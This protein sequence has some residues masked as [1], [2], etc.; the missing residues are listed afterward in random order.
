MCGI[1]GALSLNKPS[2][3]V[4]YIKPMADKIAHRGPDDAGY[5]CFHTGARHNKKISFYQNLTDEKFKN[6]EDMLPTIE[7]NSAQRELH[8]HDYDLYM[9]HR[10]LS[11]LDVSYAGHQPMS[12]LSKNIW[13]A[14]NGEIY[15]FKEL[16]IELEEL[17]HRFKSQT[18]TEVII[19]SYIEWGI[20][21]IKRFNGMFAFSLY[22]NFNKK[23][24]L[25]RDRYGIKPVYYHI[26]EDK[27]FI[28]A[29]EIKSILEYKDYKS[30]VDKEALL[31]YFTFQNIFTNKTLHK[32]IQILEAGHYFEIDLLSKE[33][34]K[35]QYW[36]FDFSESENIKDERE[37]IEELDRLFTQAVQRQLISDVPVGSYLSGGM[38]S[39]SITA[40]ASNHFQK[41][42]DFLKTFTIGFDLSSASGMELS[43]DERAKSEY[44][45][46]MFKT[47]HYEMVLK[48]GDM[49]RCMNNFAYHLEEPRVGQSYPNYYAAKLASKFVKVVLSGAG[50]DELFAGYPWRYYKAVNNDSF[51]NYIDKYYGFWKRLIPNKDIQNVFSPILKDTKVWTK[52]IFA[53]VFKTPVN[54]QTPEEYINHSL[55]FEA[56]TFLHGLLVVDDKLSMAHSL[57]TRVPF[58]DND[59]VDFA[60]KIPVKFKLGN[61]N[62]VIKMDENEIGK[63]QKTNDG[64]VILR[65]A[66]SKYIPEDIHKAVK[67]GFSSPDNSWFKGESIEFVKA[68]LLNSDANIYKYM[69]KDATQKLINEHL[70]GKQNR[71]LFVWSLLNFEEWSKIYE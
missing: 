1:V 14:Y 7:S 13:I 9:G 17:G 10:R 59:L 38:D 52:D 53:S 3:N 11:I 58:L 66:M 30:E 28:Y 46:Y 40:I 55:Y 60:Q 26:T 50:G 47:E 43:F 56:K 51:D 21:C 69:D 36:D 41:S 65:K 33:I 37:Y 18:D 29:S 15:N 6:I 49:E 63:M 27:T 48:S 8:S 42:N 68:K 22:D 35:K 54:V 71:R 64:K 67:Q 19:Y 34:E 24:Y 31:E 16:R 44:M 23:F 12:D 5:L 2:V 39:G 4:D 57:E 45:S 70:E 20:E 62:K 32:D 61:L 25:C